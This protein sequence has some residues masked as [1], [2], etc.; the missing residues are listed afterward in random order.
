MLWE[1][2]LYIWRTSR[3][4]STPSD[5]LRA[6]PLVEFVTAKTV[7]PRAAPLIS[8][9]TLKICEGRIC[10]GGAHTA[11]QPLPRGDVGLTDGKA[12]V[13]RRCAHRRPGLA[14]KSC[15]AYLTWNVKVWGKM[16]SK[17]WRPYLR[18]NTLLATLFF[19]RSENKLQSRPKNA[20][21]LQQINQQMQC[22]KEC[23]K[24]SD[25]SAIWLPK[26]Y[27]KRSQH[28]NFLIFLG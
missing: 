9:R 8:A 3:T 16:T 17:R 6:E 23:R 1:N 13:R 11:A 21:N 14:E 28:F 4:E 2:M 27:K 26:R 5:L 25:K 7:S 20:N 22:K 24:R 18:F 15:W 12:N 19:P 10:E